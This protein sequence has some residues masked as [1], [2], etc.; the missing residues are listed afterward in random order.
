MTEQTSKTRWG[1]GDAL[2]VIAFL[3]LVALGIYLFYKTWVAVG[4]FSGWLALMDRILWQYALAFGAFAAYLACLVALHVVISFASGTK[5]R[6][7]K[8]F[9]SFKHDYEPIAT[10]IE[11][12]LA[13]TDFEIVRIPF[14]AGRD[15]DDVIAESL[16]AV[17][18]A[19]A[20]IAIPGPEASWMANEL[21]LAV[22]SKKPIVVI[23]HLPAQPLSDSLYRGY[24]VFD[25]EKLQKGGLLP[26]RR[27]LAFATK[28]RGDVWPQFDRSVSGAL[29]LLVGGYM[30]F[31][32]ISSILKEVIRFLL[33]FYPHEGEV[34]ASSSIWTLVVVVAAV[35][36]V[37]FAGAFL[38]RLRGLA[39]ARQKIRTREATY[40]EFAMVFSFVSADEAI[41][42]VLERAP[43]EPSYEKKEA[44]AD[45][46]AQSAPASVPES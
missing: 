43:L 36:A 27:F 19:D 31:V 16:E 30:L 1:W 21:G 46:P 32:V 11:H 7:A 26:M 6:R 2:I 40:S 28:S 8:V 10:Q 44:R 17:R 35:F 5:L 34:L 15:H 42:R 20:V 33:A 25:W 9:I 45:V 41:L 3:A 39:I 37:G 4:G 22:G 18:S 14:R 29:N 12:G 13:G 38:R 24:P 23:K